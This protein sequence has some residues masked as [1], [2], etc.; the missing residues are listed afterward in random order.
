MNL[1]KQKDQFKKVSLNILLLRN[2]MSEGHKFIKKDAN[3]PSN[4]NGL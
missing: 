3:L 4:P 2:R 1:I